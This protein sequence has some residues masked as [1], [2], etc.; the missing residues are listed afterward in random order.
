MFDFTK[1]PRTFKKFKVPMPPAAVVRSA[2]QP[3]DAPYGGSPSDD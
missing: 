1:P 3:R 2:T